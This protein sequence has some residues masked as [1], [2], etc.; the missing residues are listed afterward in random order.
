LT[1]AEARVLGAL[2]EKQ[3]TTPDL[4]PL[5]LKALTGACNQTSNRDPVLSIDPIDVETTALVLKTKGLVRV[6]HPGS[7]ERST[8][9]RQVAD[10]VLRLDDEDRA[11][12]C[13]LLLR[14][15]QTP[16]ELRT[17]TERLHP[18][19]S[20]EAVEDALRRLAA[21]S[22]PLAQQLERR[23]GQTQARWVQLLEDEPYVAEA[24]DAPSAT[25][26][27]GPGR[28]DRVSELDDRVGQLEQ[29][30]GDRIG[31]LEQTVAD[32]ARQVA[33]LRHALGED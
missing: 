10:E 6:I 32:L 30:V 19:A 5:T 17:R 11:L 21:R 15:A 28:R 27:V 16:A 13:V 8:R 14:G 33:E 7:G 22:E 26:S 24:G 1:H 31:Q 29:Q 2:I 4:Y 23:P 20:T 12:M 9:Y 25:S 3:L 18:F